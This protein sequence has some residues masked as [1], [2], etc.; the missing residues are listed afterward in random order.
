MS[1][2]LAVDGCDAD[3]REREQVVEAEHAE[4]GRVLEQRVEH[5]GRRGRVGVRAV[6]RF[7]VGAEVRGERVQAQVRNVV[8]HEPARQPDR[9]DP[10]VRQAAGSRCGER[11]VEEPAV[12]ADVVPDD[13]RV[14][15]ELEQRRQQLFDRGRGRDHRLGDAGEH[16]DE[17]RDR[18][19]RVHERVEPAEQ[20]TAAQ[21]QRADL[22]DAV[23]RR[24]AAGGLEVDDDERDLRERG[25]RV[26]GG[27]AV[28]AGS[29]DEQMFATHTCS[30]ICREARTISAWATGIA[31]RRAG[32]SPASMWSCRA[33]PARSTTTRSAAS[34][35]IEEE[36]VLDE[37]VERVSCRWCGASGDAIEVDSDS[38]AEQLDDQAS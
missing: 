30:P 23:E 2:S 18:D 1:A 29:V 20:L 22:G 9:V 38:D 31:V 13:H 16:G 7:G 25:R 34:S 12:E 33:G 26:S 27:G 17:R 6:H 5:L 19:A 14:A 28:H 15:E 24:R 35:Q 4:R 3:P 10:A 21:L 36:E 11:G 32:T 8:A 37:R